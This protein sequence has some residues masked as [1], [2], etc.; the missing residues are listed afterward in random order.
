VVNWWAAIFN[1]SFPYRFAHMVVAAYIAG[2]FVVVGV[3]GFYLWQR[4]H[5]EFARTSLSIAMWV[6]LVLVPAQ[7]AIGDMHGLNTLKHQPVKVAAME[8]DWE[9]RA[10]QPLV[11]FAW[12]NEARERNDYEVAIPKLG[13]LILTH[14]WEGEVAGLR[15]APPQDRPPV[16]AVFFAFRAMVGIGLILLAIV[17]AGNLL[18]WRGRLYDARRFNMVCAFSSPLPFLAVLAGWTV[19]ETGRQPFVVY[20]LLRT[21]DAASPVAAGA[22]FGSLGLFVIVYAVLLLAF[23]FYAARLVLRG[24]QIEEP[25]HHPPAVRPGVETAVARGTD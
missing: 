24:P 4:R 6:L 3:S 19:T 1:P 9:T 7:I 23:F 22:V 8:G 20:G 13:S 11:L 5:R 14:E 17:L 25:E 18:R 15:A 12:P 2:M 21:A 10:G 16:P